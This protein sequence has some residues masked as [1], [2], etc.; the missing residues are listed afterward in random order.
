MSTT[1]G[2][3]M[4]ISKNGYF[5]RGELILRR[6]YQANFLPIRVTRMTLPGELKVSILEVHGLGKGTQLFENGM[7]CVPLYSLLFFYSL[8]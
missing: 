2:K 1:N 4:R 6:R 3:K 8:S 7:S 5:V